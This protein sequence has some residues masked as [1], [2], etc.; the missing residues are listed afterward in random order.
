MSHSASHNNESEHIASP[1]RE[2]LT[3]TAQLRAEVQSQLEKIERDKEENKRN[4]QSLEEELKNDVVNRSELLGEK[5]KLLSF[6][7][8]LEEMETEKEKVLLQIEKLRQII[9]SAIKEING[10]KTI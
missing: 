9:E 6:K 1:L 4:L 10:L 3:E 5:E 7:W 8:H 2:L